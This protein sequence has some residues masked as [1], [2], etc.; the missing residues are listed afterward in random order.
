[1][2]KHAEVYVKHVDG[3][4]YDA[5]WGEGWE[6]WTRFLVKKGEVIYIKGQ[7]IN[8]KDKALLAGVVKAN[9]K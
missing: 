6:N 4:M 5:F 8:T 9:E 1:M 7:P 3:R 2:D